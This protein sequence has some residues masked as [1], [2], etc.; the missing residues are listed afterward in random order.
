MKGIIL[1]G[2]RGTRLYPIT[3]TASK[4]LLPV[5][6]KPMV[7]YPLTT[8][9]LAGIRDILLITTPEDLPSYRRLLGDGERWGLRLSYVEQPAPGGLAEAYVIGAEFVGGAPSALILGD[10]VY[11]GQ[12]LSETLQAVAGRTQGA[13]IFAY[14]VTDPER[15][16][17]VEFDADGRPTSIEEKP[18]Q[19]LS[20][21]AVTG[22][23]FYDG[24]ATSIAARLKPSAR[25]ELEITD[26]NRMYLEMGE[27]TVERFGRGV[28]WLDTG[29]PESLLEASEFVRA[30]EKRQRYRIGCPE[31][32]A[33]RMGFID[34]DQLMA[35][36]RE[37]NT[38]DYGAYLR[39]IAEE[40]L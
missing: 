18:R 6:D 22:L 19:P 13:T 10:N 3:L 27:L 5:Y 8:L 11:Y 20:N 25:G 9:M 23:Y 29:T 14:S 7:Y 17:V 39:S 33:F 24:K 16:G 37:L 38:S 28:A 1:A 21:W 30:L 26:L 12:G 35:L 34:R 2:G 40:R 32:A 15:F 31:E 36:G 4:Q